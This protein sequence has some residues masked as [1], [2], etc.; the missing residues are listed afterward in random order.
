MPQL[1]TVYI[2][3]IYIWTWFILY[4]I[5]QKVKTFMIMSSPKKQQQT[6]PNKPSPTLPWT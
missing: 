3:F 4:L 2:F 1:D 5:T 6:K